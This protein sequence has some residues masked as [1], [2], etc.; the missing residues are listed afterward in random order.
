[1]YNVHSERKYSAGLWVF[2]TGSD[3]FCTSGYH[4]PLSVEAKIRQAGKVEN[5]EGVELSYPVDVNEDNVDQVRRS[6]SECRLKAVTVNPNLNNQP[7]WKFGSLTSQDAKIRQEAVQIVKKTKETAEELGAEQINFWLGQDGFDYP[8]QADYQRAWKL[9][10]KGIR[11]CAE[12]KPKVRVALEYKLKEP[13]THSYMSMASKVLLLIKEI[14]LDNLGA[15]LDTGHALQ[16]QENMAEVACLLNS[17][18]KLFHLHLNDNFRDWDHDMIVGT[19]HFWEYLELF[20]WLQFIGYEG[21]YS[22]DL[23]PYR[24]DPV[25]ACNQSIRNVEGMNRLIEQVGVNNLIEMVKEGRL[26]E[27][28]ETLT[29]KLIPS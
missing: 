15:T 4:E 19:V 10:V 27:I 22:L 18:G 8:F 16:A 13:R 21:W 11:E 14:G 28:Q 2:G 23:F 24:I 1:M 29:K 7:K 25:Q 3:R 9:L 26:A 12:W 17:H 5:L 20:L 6:L